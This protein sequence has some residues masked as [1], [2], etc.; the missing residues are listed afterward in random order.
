MLWALVARVQFRKDWNYVSVV[1]ACCDANACA[2]FCEYFTPTRVDLLPLGH[3]A[4][5]AP[6]HVSPPLETCDPATSLVLL[7]HIDFTSERRLRMV[8]C[9]ES[10]F[11]TSKAKFAIGWVHGRLPWRELTHKHKFS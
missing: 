8:V 2:G 10:R 1:S 6:E 5:H 7:V 4:P 3:R 11:D 9:R